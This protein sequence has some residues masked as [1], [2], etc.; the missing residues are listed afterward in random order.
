[1]IST[2]SAQGQYFSRPA[3]ERFP[4][5]EAL[6]TAALSDEQRC[7][8]AEVPLSGLLAVT[9]GADVAVQGKATGVIAT[10]THW[11]FAQV[12]RLVGAPA[13]YLRTLPASLAVENLNHGFKSAAE[14]PAQLYLRRE[15]DSGLTLRA[16][17]TPTYS[18]YHDAD[19]VSRLMQLRDV[20]PGLDLPP[21]WGKGGFG[22][23]DGSKGGAYRGDRDAF[24]IMTDGGS[25]VDDPTVGGFGGGNGTMYRGIIARNST[26]GASK[27]E[28]LT[29]YFRGICGNHCIWGVE[30]QTSV[31]R[32]HVGDV[33]AAFEDMIKAA[34]VWLERPASEDVAKI[35]ALN[36]IELGK[37]KA[38]TVKAGRGYGLTE[39]QA[40]NSYLAAEQFEQNP[41]SVWGYSNGVTRISQLSSYQDTRFIMDQIAAKMLRVKVAA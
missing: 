40:E 17:T 23:N 25:I 41:R 28:L 24:V 37:D 31:Q 6:H 1:M 4:S 21:V 18:R 16:A 12:A 34:T 2:S 11:S 30:Q 35:T 26:V 20:R 13:A 22:S 32:R 19:F 36:T 10:L 14:D 5:L 39:E 29:F 7:A 27:L 33:A 8:K 15:A 38:E 3:D 9:Q